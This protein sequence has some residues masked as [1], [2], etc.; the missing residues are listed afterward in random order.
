LIWRSNTIGALPYEV[1]NALEARE[2]RAL[3]KGRVG[4]HKMREVASPHGEDATRLRALVAPSNRPEVTRPKVFVF[5][6]QS[7]FAQLLSFA[8]P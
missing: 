1:G 8:S 7:Q 6:R 4:G 3:R 2:G 5:E